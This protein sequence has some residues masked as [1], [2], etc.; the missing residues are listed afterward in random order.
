MSHVEQE[1]L[2]LSEHPRP[3]SAFSGVGVARSLVFCVVFC[4]SLFFLFLAIVFSVL[5]FTA[6]DYPFGI[7]NLFSPLSRFSE[8]HQS[9]QE[10]ERSCV[11][12][13]AVMCMCMRYRFC[14]CFYNFSNEIWNRFHSVVFFTYYCTNSNYYY[15]AQYIYKGVYRYHFV[16]QKVT[17]YVINR[18]NYFISIYF[19]YILYVINLTNSKVVWF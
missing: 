16:I 8:I 3:P 9:S 14:H 13:W 18:L 19:V 5:R 11:C 10:S 6:S 4:R 12:V 7:F 1:L 17:R 15:I 2:T